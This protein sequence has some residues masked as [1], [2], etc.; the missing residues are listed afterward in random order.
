MTLPWTTQRSP[1]RTVRGP[2]ATRSAWAR[3]VAVTAAAGALA[4]FG[5]LGGTA[6]SA[7]TARH[8]V[9]GAAVGGRAELG[10]DEAVAGT[11]L[12]GVRIYRSWGDPVL[13]AWLAGA[14]AGHH[15]PFVSVKAQRANGSFVSFRAIADA[16]PGD[17][18]Y[19]E[20][21]AQAKDLKRYGRPVWFIFNHEPEAAAS[22]PSGSGADFQ[23]AWR[24][25]RRVH[26]EQGVRNVRYA[27]T[28]TAWS[29]SRTDSGAAANYY[30]GDAYVDAI[31]ADGYNWYDCR[32]ASQSWVGFAD[33]FRGQRDFGRRHPREQLMVMEFG[34]VE[35]AAHP[36][37]KAAWFDQTRALLKQPAWSQ[38]SAAMSWNGRNYT[39]PTSACSFDY[40]SSAS[41][42]AA[43]VRFA[44][45]SLVN[46][47]P[48]G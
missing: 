16:R 12:D 43:W 18:L 42:R 23:A 20:L 19:A 25:I 11:S 9:F 48:A 10:R 34:S 5:A 28:L 22:R 31:A 1:R 2:A 47:T 41:A 3:A 26:R 36:G 27:L 17:R 8:V 44:H 6:A 14:D 37:R 35:D 40:D 4:L 39:G 30:P 29:F 13:P 21:V 38:Y 15:L 46:D 45:D 24:T 33:I 32:G 7:A